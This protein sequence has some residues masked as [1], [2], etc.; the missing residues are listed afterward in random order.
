MLPVVPAW[1]GTV[2]TARTVRPADVS[3]AAPSSDVG[4]TR[5]DDEPG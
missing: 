4:G 5:P 2:E 1:P 3:F